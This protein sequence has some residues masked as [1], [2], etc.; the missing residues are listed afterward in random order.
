MRILPT[1]AMLLS[2]CAL[3]KNLEPYGA[4]PTLD[5]TTEQKA[6]VE[7][8]ELVFWDKSEDLPQNRFLREGSAIFRVNAA[9]E[10]VW[11]VISDFSKYP[12]WAYK[13]GDAKEYKPTESGKHHVEFKAQIV[14]KKYYVVHDFPVSNR[15][16]GTWHSDHDKKSECVLD[17]VGFWRVDPVKEHP[18]QSDVY[19]SGKVIL[20][21]TCAKGFLGVGGFN[22]KDMAHQTFDKI[23]KRV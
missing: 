18:N 4:N 14:G 2:V 7:K 15:G 19:Y 5:L 22:A 23:K 9:P 6:K 1:L 3:A 20:N 21:R 11:K 17:T 16:V 12:Q 13:V 8:G 10:A